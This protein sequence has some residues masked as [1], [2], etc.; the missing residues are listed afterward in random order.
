MRE[1]GLHSLN[2]YAGIGFLRDFIEENRKAGQR[3]RL[4]ILFKDNDRIARMRSLCKTAKLSEHHSRDK[5]WT[6][7]FQMS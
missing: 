2:T 6:G 4:V 3:G 1:E 7:N 5:R